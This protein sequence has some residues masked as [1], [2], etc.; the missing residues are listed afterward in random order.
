MESSITGLI[1]LA[2]AVVNDWYCGDRGNSGNN[3]DSIAVNL[4]AWASGYDGQWS[5]ERVSI[6][7]SY[8]FHAVLLEIPR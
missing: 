2:E 3:E 4:R 6:Y 7:F 5:S 8:E 1:L